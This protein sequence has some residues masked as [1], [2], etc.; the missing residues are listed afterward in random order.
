MSFE[1]KIKLPNGY[2]GSTGLPKVKSW[3]SKGGRRVLTAATDVEVSGSAVALTA[4]PVNSGTVL[5]SWGVDP[6]DT[7]EAGRGVGVYATPVCLTGADLTDATAGLSDGANTLNCAYL[8]TSA[9]V[10]GTMPVNTL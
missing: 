2:Q 3:L 4:A 7:T 8:D 5:V 9:K 10:A 1:M 6:S